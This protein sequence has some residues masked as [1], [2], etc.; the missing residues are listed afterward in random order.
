MF[1]NTS[2]RPFRFHCH[3]M[4]ELKL[5]T[6]WPIVVHRS[7]TKTCEQQNS[8]HG[9]QS[10]VTFTRQGQ[11]LNRVLCWLGR[12]PLQENALPLSPGHSHRDNRR[13]DEAMGRRPTVSRKLKST[14]FLPPRLF[15]FSGF[16][17]VSLAC[18][19]NRQSLCPTPCD[20]TSIRLAFRSAEF[21]ER[22]GQS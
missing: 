8:A 2:G 4:W 22:F 9:C 17:E 3:A 16:S 15:R 21:L 14:H 13:S 11:F 18:P 19:K 7:T 5:P 6:N 10:R 20:H 1:A 12:T